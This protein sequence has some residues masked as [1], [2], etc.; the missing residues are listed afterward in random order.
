MSTQYALPEVVREVE[1][2]RQQVQH[3]PAHE[4]LNLAVFLP[5]VQ[6]NIRYATAD[7]LLRE[8]LYTEAAAYLR[9]PAAEAL[10][11]VQAALAAHDAGLLVF[12]AYRPYS[13]TVR[14]W[15]Q[16]QDETYAAPPWRGS[17]HNRGCSVDVALVN[18]HTGLPLPMPTAFDA[19]TPAAHSAYEPVPPE[20]RHNR[21]LLLQTMAQFGFVNYPG[22]WWHFDFAA[23]ADFTLLD[24]PFEQL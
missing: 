19:L 18:L 23:W 17:R 3:N 13:V 16:I 2:Y 6:L 8:P 10:R 11:E 21:K 22:E 9:R 12:D 1:E 5:E 15:E 14:F 24:L 4:L 20:V 7:N